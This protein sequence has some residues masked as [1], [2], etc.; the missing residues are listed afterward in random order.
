[1]PDVRENSVEL[2]SKNVF[3]AHVSR[4]NFKYGSS[5]HHTF[6]NPNHNVDQ[7]QLQDIR[8][9]H[10]STTELEILLLLK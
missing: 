5:S 4:N 2:P 1:M 6:Y 7:G 10:F 9:R 3:N 8:D